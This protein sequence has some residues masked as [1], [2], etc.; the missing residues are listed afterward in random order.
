[1]RLNTKKY[2]LR[3]TEIAT[4]TKALRLKSWSLMAQ[5]DCDI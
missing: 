4:A 2:V 3:A 5:I 1:L